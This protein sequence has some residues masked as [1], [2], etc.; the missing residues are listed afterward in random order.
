MTNPSPYYKEFAPPNEIAHLVGA[1]WSFSMP[2][3]AACN[4]SVPYRVLPDG[5]M[6]LIF[7]YQRSTNGAIDSPSLTVYG[8]TDRYYIVDIKPSTQLIGV[9]F[10]PGMAGVFL[11]HNPINLFQQ[12][13]RAQD[14][15]EKFVQVFDQ[16]CECSSTA[17]ALSTLQI[18]LLKIQRVDREDSP[19]I[20]EALRLISTS[21]GQ[22]SVSQ[23][24]RA[25]GVSER[26]LRRG[27]TTVVGLSPKVLARILRFQSAVSSIRLVPKLQTQKE[28]SSSD[29][30]RIALDCG[31]ADQAHM[32]REF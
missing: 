27:V 18:N 15:S 13:A 30:C 1:F 24:A 4:Y 17:Q 19:S 22:I 6:D 5:C 20:R 8:S 26:T 7:R 31:Y 32:G 11:R 29:L 16:L 14:C 10:N 25:I 21:K 2:D 3:K 9:R 28:S 12:E 23:V